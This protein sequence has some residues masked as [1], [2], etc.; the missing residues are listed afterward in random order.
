MCLS[1]RS[2]R[3]KTLRVSADQRPEVRRRRVRLLLNYCQTSLRRRTI[4][5]K[6]FFSGRF[7]CWSGSSWSTASAWT[8]YHPSPR[9]CW[10]VCQTCSRSADLRQLGLQLPLLG[11][12]KMSRL[13]PFINVFLQHF[14]SRSCQLV[15]GAGALQVVGL[16]TITTKNLGRVLKTF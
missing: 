12:W 6:F 14:N 3:Q 5:W 16:K 4:T 15:L 13:N 10:R 2:R 8:T 7:C 1:C 11:N 9:R